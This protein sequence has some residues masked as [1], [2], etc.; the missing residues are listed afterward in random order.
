M[1]PLRFGCCCLRIYFQFRPPIGL[2]NVD[3]ISV[4]VIHGRLSCA[5]TLLGSFPLLN[6]ERG[7]GFILQLTS[8]VLPFEG[9]VLSTPQSRNE[10]ESQTIDDLMAILSHHLVHR[11]VDKCRPVKRAV[12]ENLFVTRKGDAIRA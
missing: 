9:D 1:N 4:R 6:T 2:I 7:T 3:G 12:Y 11:L 5:I 8:V 10:T